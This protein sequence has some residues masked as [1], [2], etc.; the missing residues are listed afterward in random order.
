MEKREILF[1]ETMTADKRDP[2]AAYL[3]KNVFDSK[4]K[5]M[6]PSR[7]FTVAVTPTDDAF[8]ILWADTDKT[9]SN[10]NITEGLTFVNDQATTTLYVY[11]TNTGALVETRANTQFVNGIRDEDY[12]M[13]AILDV[14]GVY[15]MFVYYGG[16][17][18]FIDDNGVITGGA[19]G[20]GLE[21]GLFDGLNNYWLESN[22][23]P[24]IWRSETRDEA[25]TEVFTNAG[26]YG[27]GIENYF[28]QIVLFGQNNN[29]T[30]TYVLFW[31]K[32]NNTLF[33]KRII[34]N[35]A[36]FMAG[37]LINGQLILVTVQGNYAN[38]K[39]KEGRLI[40]SAY[41]G[42]KFQ[43]INSIKLGSA[44]V[45]RTHTRR[46]Y[47]V[48]NNEI[49][50]GLQN[51]DLDKDELYEN[52]LV[53]VKAD[54]SIDVLWSDPTYVARYPSVNFE[55]ITFV[56]G[57]PFNSGF[58]DLDDQVYINKDD[59]TDYET[60]DNFTTTE[61]VT[62]FLNNT[63]NV[64]A[65]KG[66]SIVF[67]KIHDDEELEIYYRT[68]DREDFVLL[69]TVNE[70]ALAKSDL[71]YS[72]AQK[73]AER[74]PGNRG[75]KQQIYHVVDVPGNDPLPEYNEIQFKFKST[76][77]FSIIQ[78]WYNYSYIERNVLD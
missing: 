51:N 21:F 1:A 19:D 13:N 73:V 50:F 43:E 69:D 38:Q 9:D 70:A 74:L 37:G 54:G 3:R 11:E 48:G 27:T 67:E 32:T 40:V 30:S 34:I 4:S 47:A 39:E 28:D 49:V 72:D 10:G 5:G 44:N 18:S 35:N 61:Y 33:D 77:G 58:T 16:V 46:N 24:E 62:N 76:N 53:R 59:A 75:I 6:Y 36:R 7:D 78:V 20:Q 14:N 2:E 56:K 12:A 26:I 45:R 57:L 64:H 31:D 8:R 65:L 68:S 29:E 63:Y 23:N 25:F 66:M 52:W 41:D 42:Q 60:Y 17:G 71:R 55:D 15:R 22:S